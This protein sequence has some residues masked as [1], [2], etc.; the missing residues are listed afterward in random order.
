MTAGRVVDGAAFVVTP[1]DNKLHT[2]NETA[3][4]LWSL[5]SEELTATA[6]TSAIV[7]HFE[8]DSETAAPDVQQCLADLVARQ[9]LIAT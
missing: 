2:L 9:I 6:A 8:V 3:T 7:E 1:D 5:A 4:F